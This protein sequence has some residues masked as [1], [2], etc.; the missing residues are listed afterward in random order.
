MRRL[1]LALCLALLPIA[2]AARADEPPATPPV[3]SHGAFEPGMPPFT[4][5]LAKANAAGKP[6]FLEIYTTTCG[7]CRRLERDVLPQAEVV[8]ALKPFVCARYD[9]QDGEG[10]E[11]AARYSVRLYPTLVVVDAE[12]EEVDR[13]VGY[14]EP[15]AFVAEVQR[16]ARGEGTLPVLLKALEANPDDFGALLALARRERNTDEAAAAKLLERVLA[17]A[18]GKDAGAVADALL[19]LA[20]LE[21]RTRDRAET[22][23]HREE[24]AKHLERLLRDHPESKAAGK[25][26]GALRHVLFTLPAERASVLLEQARKSARDPEDV[27]IAEQ[28]AY[29]W[30]QGQAAEAMKKWG[31]AAEKDG[32]ALNQV[33]WTAYLQKISP[34]AAV[35]W[36]RKAVELTD[37]DPAVLDTLANLLFAEGNLDEAIELEEEALKKAEQPEHALEFAVNIAM[38]KAAR[39]VKK[40]HAAR[41]KAGNLDG[42]VPPGDRR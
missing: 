34:Q 11:V 13:F 40:L 4:D 19:A 12:G 14:H 38:W 5:L 17:R 3:A 25:A 21:R 33:A 16:I 41:E 26:G 8:A 18:E 30:H 1:P 27:L 42:G 23:K 22:L 35:R 9:A 29:V 2:S 39:D 6:V 10:I 28:L 36:A 37:R 24:A 32:Q 20:S 15:K 31:A 7:Y